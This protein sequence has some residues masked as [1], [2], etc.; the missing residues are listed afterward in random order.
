M[1]YPDLSALRAALFAAQE[2][3]YR[4]FQCSLMPTVPPATV[5]G[6]RTPVLRRMARELAGTPTADVLMATLPHLTFEENQL[7]AFLIE[8]IR[9]FD[10]AITAT[11]A[12]LPYVDNWATCDQLSPRVFK[13]RF[14]KL[15][16]HIDRW[17]AD[18]S[19]T[20]TLRFGIGMLM[21]YG[22]D[23]EFHPDHLE[24][25]AR[26]AVLARED[27]Y[28]RMMIAW[29]FATALAKQYD[30]ALPYIRDRR[31]PLWTHRRTIQKACESFRVTDEHK[32]V[33]KLF[34]NQ[35]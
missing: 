15:K 33:L 27:F 26:P 18:D 6:V 34:R 12:F 31:L 7:H 2:E 13:G 25:V 5:I 8:P 23:E 21:R 28:I 3:S 35:I 20:Y 4:A 9:D 32:A 11:D 29:F 24:A 19:P 30:A 10:A 16:P 17:M 14:P 1:I 22:L